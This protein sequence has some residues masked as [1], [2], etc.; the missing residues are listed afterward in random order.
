MLP[1]SS[2]TEETGSIEICD[3]NHFYPQYKEAIKLKLKAKPVDN[4][5][6]KEI[7]SYFSNKFSVPKSKVLILKGEKSRYKLVQIGD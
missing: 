4:A 6:N 1:N 2:I 5:A 3:D 7:I